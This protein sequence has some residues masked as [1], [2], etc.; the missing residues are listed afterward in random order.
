MTPSIRGL[1][2]AALGLAALPASATTIELEVHGLVCAFCAQGIE[3][4]LRRFDATEDVFVSLEHGLVAVA[5]A[6]GADLADEKLRE[7]LTEA[8]Y[9]VVGISRSESTIAEIEA[10]IDSSGR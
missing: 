2:F 5:L 3:K 8:G 6:D 1:A 10:R 4:S 7:A 9:T